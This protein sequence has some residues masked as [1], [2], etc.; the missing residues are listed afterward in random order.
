LRLRSGTATLA[1][2]RGV[3]LTVEGPADIDLVAI[4]RVFCRQ[5]RLRAHVPPG[6][7][8]FI[9]ASPESA[10]A[11]LGT[12]FGLNVEANG[13][14]HVMVFQGSAEAALLDAAGAPEHL[15]ILGQSEAIELD[16][17]SGRIAMVAALASRF[18]ASPD[19]E[20]PALILDAGYPASV[21]ESRPR[22]YWRFQ[23]RTEGGVPNEV[24]G[25]PPLRVRGPVAI[26][27][28]PGGDGCAVF[29][30]DAPEQF[31]TLDDTW[32]LARAPGQAVELWFLADAYGYASLVG[33]YPPR[34]LNPAGQSERYLHVFFVEALAW[35]VH[36]LHKPPAIRFL[37]RWPLD[38]AQQD[39]LYSRRAYAPRIWHHVVAQ[40]NE[41][42]M[43][44]FFD[45]AM[46]QAVPLVPDRP[47]VPCH[48]VVGRRTPDVQDPKDSRSFVGRLDE[49]ALYDRP[50]SAEEV[51]RHYR[52]AL[53]ESS[54]D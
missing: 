54:P 45:G 9:V 53:E 32:E 43:E 37:S 19:L 49:L 50:L 28:G 22:G 20:P 33:L 5:G 23:A 47:A 27:V 8:G 51:R 12:E 40:M 25:G 15:R 39:N 48:V 1:F 3:T 41:G 2:L 46:S 21:L 52:L 10:V 44:L 26:A 7:E 38:I 36:A 24:A 30:P 35:G 13:K 17:R 18:V 14:S 16:P 34:E 42:R 31:L 11:D 29:R 4:D 6:A